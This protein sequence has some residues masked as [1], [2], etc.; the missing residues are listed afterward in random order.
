MDY[1]TAAA[2]FASKLT[3]ILAGLRGFEFS[4]CGPQGA[5]YQAESGLCPGCWRMKA[6]GHTADCGMAALIRKAGG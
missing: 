3:E 5:L 6:E 4:D 2:E 1:Q